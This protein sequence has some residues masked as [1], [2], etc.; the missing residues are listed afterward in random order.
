MLGA[1]GLFFVENPWEW[2][3]MGHENAEIQE[4]VD[5]WSSD[6]FPSLMLAERLVTTWMS[7]EVSKLLV[8]GL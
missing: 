6:P 3:M 4:T 7:Q 1:A 5:K 8:N 2:M